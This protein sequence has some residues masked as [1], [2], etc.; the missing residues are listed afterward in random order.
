MKALRYYA[1]QDIRFEDVPEPSPGPGE[2]K[3]KISFAGICGS[4]LHEFVDGPTAIARFHP[5]GSPV[6]NGHEFSGK[7][8]E[9]GQGV[10]DFQ[11]GDRVTGMGYW[12][13]GECNFCKQGKFNICIG[14]NNKG[15]LGASIDG[16]MAE[17]MVA[18]SKVMV[19]LPDS[20][21][22]E[23]GAVAE[24][25]ACGVHAVNQGNVHP[26]DTVAVVG[27]GPIGLCTMLAAKAADAS[28]VYVV[29][30]HKSRGKIASEMGATKVIDFD[31]DTAKLIK[32][33]TGGLGVDVSFDCVGGADT[34]E[35]SV[36]L[37]RKGGT[38]VIVGARGNNPIPFHFR[39]IFSVDRT[40]VGSVA[41]N[42]E[43]ETT[44]A[45][46]ADKKIDPSR[47]IT[48]KVP[49]KDGVEKGFKALVDNKDNNLKIL[50]IP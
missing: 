29:S 16:C 5:D 32:D 39:K 10:T 3:V 42:R 38:T 33:L 27:D 7:V 30:K 19:K 11:V 49:L 2:V 21:S 48:A 24:P 46:L 17:Y 43:M 35:L 31:D 12:S 14:Q 45:L 25:L 9:V 47:L 15:E 26:G 22:D 44:V 23:I 1:K 18:P 41:Y 4:N 13:C 8:V 40:I 36:D 50:L 6:T 28:A 34:P 37:T 20:V